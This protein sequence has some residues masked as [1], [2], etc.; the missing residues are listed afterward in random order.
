MHKI[1][2]RRKKI[3]E[4]LPNSPRFPVS[5]KFVKETRPNYQDNSLLK[6]INSRKYL[7]SKTKLLTQSRN[8]LN[9]VLTA[10]RL[11]SQRVE[12]LNSEYFEYFGNLYKFEQAETIMNQ[13]A[14][15]IQKWVKGFFARRK[16]DEVL[17]GILRNLHRNN[18]EEL[19]NNSN[20]CLL[21]IGKKPREAAIVLQ[22]AVRRRT[23]LQKIS[24]IATVYEAF[25]AEKVKKASEK[26]RKYMG[27]FG[28]KARLENL[29]WLRYKT[30]KLKK[31][32]R[33]LAILVIKEVIKR[34]KI[35]VRLMRLK[36][37]KYR[38][39]SLIRGSPVKIKDKKSRHS[40]KVD[41]LLP[42][43][44][45][46]DSVTVN[47]EAV[48][49][50]TEKEHKE[51]TLRLEQEKKEKLSLCLISYKV[52]RGRYKFYRKLRNN[53]SNS[54]V[55]SSNDSSNIKINQSKTPIPTII[56]EKPKRTSISLRTKARLSN[57]TPENYRKDNFLKHTICSEFNRTKPIVEEE[58]IEISPGFKYHSRG[59]IL[60]PTLSSK[61][62]LKNKYNFSSNPK[63]N[64]NPYVKLT[65]TPSINNP[66]FY[67]ERLK[68]SKTPSPAILSQNESN[69]VPPK[70]SKARLAVS[71]SIALSEARPNLPL[72]IPNKPKPFR[73]TLKLNIYKVRGYARP[74][75]SRDADVNITFW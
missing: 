66:D 70:R 63:W 14:I 55:V 40:L 3:M 6:S 71:E 52:N 74:R 64:I 5:M 43:N 39:N 32:R 30:A 73:S 26:L 10:H 4:L 7:N 41:N 48:S 56:Q 2:E 27:L 61:V 49:T 68:F 17:V 67:P 15:K 45:S 53:S 25:R 59:K 18:M 34:E 47:E 62:K 37:R 31:I 65:Y 13:A 28:C 35:N 50:N 9:H 69:L 21:N 33:K 23:F 16:T 12:S 58:P 60:L 11:L 42:F 38:R 51:K 19:K 1:E 29:S 75:G 24:R 54:I 57:K 44:A 8:E 46:E 36:V 72:F 20:Y 22:R